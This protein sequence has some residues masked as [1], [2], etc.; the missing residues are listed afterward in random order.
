M[1]PYSSKTVALFHSKYEQKPGCWLWKGKV[2]AEGYGRVKC[3]GRETTAHHFAYALLHGSVPTGQHVDHICRVR[4][5][6]N[7]AHLE[8]VSCAENLKRGVS[9][10]AINRRKKL[11]I[12]GHD[13]WKIEKS[14]FRRCQTCAKAQAARYFQQ[15]TKPKTAMQ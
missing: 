11:C 14:G 4:A 15:V 8:A 1:I 12:R 10:S 9:P 6:V 13:N 2:S 7:P 5:C 3:M